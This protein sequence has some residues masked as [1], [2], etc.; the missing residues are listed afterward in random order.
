[1]AVSYVKSKLVVLLV[2]FILLYS[3]YYSNLETKY[4]QDQANNL[5][6]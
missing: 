6:L 1:M 4:L 2:L 3:V 5:L